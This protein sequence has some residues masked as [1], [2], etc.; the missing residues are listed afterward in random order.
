MFLFCVGKIWSEGIS[1]P[2]CLLLRP[3]LRASNRDLSMFLLI[4]IIY[5]SIFLFSIAWFIISS[6]NRIIQQHFAM[7]KADK[8]K[9]WHFI[10][11]FSCIIT[12]NS[13]FDYDSNRMFLMQ[14]FLNR[15][16]LLQ[17]FPCLCKS[18]CLPVDCSYFLNSVLFQTKSSL[19]W[20]SNSKNVVTNFQT[21]PSLVWKLF[22][23]N[24]WGK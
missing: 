15:M 22:V 7:N 2:R 20:K 9:S 8:N 19:V 17:D 3:A 12:I 24:L 1:T 18:P 23:L 16:S 21:K 13:N 11:Y 6:V 4:H 5:Y 14:N 10:Y